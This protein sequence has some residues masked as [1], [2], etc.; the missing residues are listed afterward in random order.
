MHNNKYIMDKFIKKSGNQMFLLFYKLMRGI[1]IP[2][3]LSDEEKIISK[4][5]KNECTKENGDCY[6]YFQEIEKIRQSKSKEKLL[7]LQECIL[8]LMCYDM[9]ISALKLGF[10]LKNDPYYSLSKN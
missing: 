1:D 4:F 5:I 8:Q 10:I 3:N 6:K 9:F 7:H 2:E